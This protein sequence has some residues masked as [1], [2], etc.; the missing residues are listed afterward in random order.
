MEDENRPRVLIMVAGELGQRLCTLLAAHR[1]HVVSTDDQDAVRAFAA[2]GS[3]APA[4]TVAIVDLRAVAG[5]RAMAALA[6][7][8]DRPF[9]IGL[10]DRPAEIDAVAHLV[11]VT[12]APPLD[13]V[14]VS[15]SA[16]E[17]IAHRR[18]RSTPGRRLDGQ[19]GRAGPEQTAN[20]RRE[21][22][23]VELYAHVEVPHDGIIEIL[24]IH[25]LSEG[26]VF[27]AARRGEFPWL[28]VGTHLDLTIAV[29]EAEEEV[30]G[31]ESSSG[32]DGALVPV[33]GHVVRRSGSGG[34]PGVGVAFIGL[35]PAS[36][37]RLRRII[38]RVRPGTR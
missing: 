28:A 16:L 1:F 20:E 9:L 3:R 34:R 35:D 30:P 33:R 14:R 6:S 37:A 21:H 7:A 12:F 5:V 8:V 2:D 18:A 10:V 36:R 24:T 23:R 26:G 32:E 4:S 17:G 25:D 27:L 13:P 15:A 38:A 29:S 19:T 31:E 11:D 22:A